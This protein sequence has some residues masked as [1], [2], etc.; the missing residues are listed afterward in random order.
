MPSRVTIE[1]PEDSESFPVEFLDAGE[2]DEPPPAV[3]N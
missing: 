2:E 1:Q 3:P